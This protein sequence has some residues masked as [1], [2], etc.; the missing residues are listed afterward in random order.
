[1]WKTF[2]EAS[3]VFVYVMTCVLWNNTYPI[4]YVV[5]KCSVC[6]HTLCDVD[7]H[8]VMWTH[9][10]CDVDTHFVMWTHAL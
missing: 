9:T 3:D 7:T 1:M 5:L 10:L 8:F 2:Y 6:G 4:F